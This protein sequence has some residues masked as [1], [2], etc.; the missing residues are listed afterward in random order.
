MHDPVPRGL[1]NH[2]IW[3]WLGGGWFYY[4][5]T[6]EKIPA[7]LQSTDPNE[8]EYVIETVDGRE[9]T[10]DTDACFPHWPACG[11]VNVDG[12]AVILERQQMRQ[13]RRTYNT[14]CLD[15]KV[16]R[17]W[18]VMKRYPQVKDMTADCFELVE[19]AFK[20]E[21]PTYTEALNRLAD[22]WA[23]VALNPYLIVAGTREEQLIYYRSKLVARIVGVRLHPLDV[24]DKRTG[25]ILKWFDGRITSEIIRDSR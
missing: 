21:Y 1:S 22:R 5:D 25:R 8:E 12:Y 16:P 24:A 7:R 17:K 4:Q 23:S 2:D 10:F 14:R 9:F 11:A 18:E 3:Q 15:I 20:P 13:W 19:A 6:D